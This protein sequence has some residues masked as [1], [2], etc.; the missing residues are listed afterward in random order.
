M[1]KFILL[2]LL[3]FYA[4]C[5]STHSQTTDQPK[6][7][8]PENQAKLEESVKKAFAQLEKNDPIAVYQ[9][10]RTV[11]IIKPLEFYSNSQNK[12]VRLVVLRFLA[13]LK[14]DEAIEMLVRGVADAESY[15]AER[16]AE[17]LFEN[18]DRQTLQDNSNLDDVLGKS[19]LE[20]NDSI[21]TYVLL[22]YFPNSANKKILENKCAEVKNKGVPADYLDTQK[23]L[24]ACIVLSGVGTEK[25]ALL[26]EK[27]R[28]AA[29][30]SFG[31]MLDNLDLIDDPHTLEILFQNTITD[32]QPFDPVFIESGVRYANP[33][34]AMR[35]LDLVI[36]RYAQH[37]KV[38][39]GFKLVEE[40]RYGKLQVAAARRKI[41]AAIAALKSEN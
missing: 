7:L 25:G 33:K 18:Y 21:A 34:Y 6:P 39:V 5:C 35:L 36:N 29:G 24:V 30:R 31:S 37:L 10:P 2:S 22:S 38:D 3:S 15:N 9:L 28:T 40:K 27:F 1:R 16:A 26:T 32:D 13:L 4:F 23:S 11:K 17:I 8:E 12:D 20:G 41:L 19:V 14:A